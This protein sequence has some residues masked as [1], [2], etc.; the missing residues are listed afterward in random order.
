MP[1]FVGAQLLSFAILSC[2]DWLRLSESPGPSSFQPVSP[3][4]LK[5]T[6]EPKAPGAPA[7]I[8]FREVDRDDRGLTAHEDVYFR[9]KILTEEGR[10]YADIEIPFFK[11]ARQASS[12][13]TREPS[14]PTAQSSTSAARRS[15]SRSS[16]RGA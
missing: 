3:E 6:S 2:S 16:R 7:I 5:M 13:S 4:E 1:I 11:E 15:I 12:I 10:K 9:I 8:L 14:S